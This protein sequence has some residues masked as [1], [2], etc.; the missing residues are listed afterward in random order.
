ME[1]FFPQF[2][3]LSF[4]A[5]IV[6]RLALGGLFLYDAQKLWKA[7]PKRRI[8]AAASGLLGVLIAI[9]LFT[10]IAVV[11]AGIQLVLSLK[12]F[13]TQSVFA[14]RA[15]VV[16]SAAILLFLLIAGPGGIAFDLP[17]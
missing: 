17:Y 16:L 7:E 1:S 10:Q 13:P 11:A 4:V 8:F 12:K 2:F 9:G 14:N 15:V 5:P 3:F 6:L